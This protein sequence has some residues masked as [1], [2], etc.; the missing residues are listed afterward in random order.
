MVFLFLFT[1]AHKTVR[2]E[3]VPVHEV[4]RAWRDVTV[5]FFHRCIL[6]FD[7]DIAFLLTV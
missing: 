1:L 7:D 6:V 3:R 4:V 2:G 5:S